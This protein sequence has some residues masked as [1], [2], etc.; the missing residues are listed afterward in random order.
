MCL[1]RDLG[2]SVAESACGTA[3]CDIDGDG[4]ITETDSLLMSNLCDSLGCAFDKA[5]YMGGGGSPLEP[6]MRS[7]R[8]ADLAVAPRGCRHPEAQGVL[9]TRRRSALDFSLTAKS[10]R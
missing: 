2:K 9:N 6:D 7:Q 10:W 1:E 5:E 3:L 8:A 4:Q